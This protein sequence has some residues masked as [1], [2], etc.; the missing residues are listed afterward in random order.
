MPKN[1]QFKDN[2]IYNWLSYAIILTLIITIGCSTQRSPR[3]EEEHQ[4]SISGSSS[5]KMPYR[6][7]DTT[8]YPI[9]SSSGFEQTGLASWYGPKFH[10]KLT[11]NQEVYDMHEMTAAH[12]TL[13]FHTKVRVINLENGKEAVVRINDRGPFVK[14]RIIDLSFKA[15]TILGIVKKGTAKVRIIALNNV[16]AGSSGYGNGDSDHDKTFT[17]QIASFQELE[18]AKLL[19]EK[20][21]NS[22]IKSVTRSNITYYQV[23]VGNYPTFDQAH[24]KM[25]NLRSHGYDSAFVVSTK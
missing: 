22:R 7:K 4:P 3:Y 24:L 1:I 16:K 10:G 19:V 18:N 25:E 6:V 21:N 11:S 13:P 23:I 12:K 8:Y 17:V 15:A 20:T 5:S 14:T 2:S 9:A